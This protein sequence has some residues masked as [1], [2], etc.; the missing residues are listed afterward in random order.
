MR[1]PT[2]P[3][4]THCAR[5]HKGDCWRLTGAC[6]VCGSNEHK[7]KDCLR[8]RSYTAPQTGGIASAV[9]KGSKDNK[10]IASQSAPRQAT[11][12]IS[13]HNAHAPSEALFSGKFWFGTLLVFWYSFGILAI[14]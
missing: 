13:R 4:C 11:Q 1:G 3:Y 2:S 12:T 9:Q 7:V 14:S 10:R 6:L 5:R 8:A